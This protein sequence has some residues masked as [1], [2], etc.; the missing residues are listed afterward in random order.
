MMKQIGIKITALILA[1]ASA[2][3]LLSAC[4]KNDEADWEDTLPSAVTTS[5]E[6]TV[7]VIEEEIGR[8]HV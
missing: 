4:G 3:A 2:A 5:S 8:A 7:M 6:G 1:A